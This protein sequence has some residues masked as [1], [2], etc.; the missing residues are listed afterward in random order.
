MPAEG[1]EIRAEVAHVHGHVRYG[2]ARIHHHDRT[3]RVCHLRDARD[4]VDRA[5]HVRLMCDGNDP[6]PLGDQVRIQI[7]ASVV[8]DTEP[9]QGGAGALGD[10]LPRHEICVVFHLRDQDLV[11]GS[12][13]EA[14][15]P[16]VERGVAERVRDHV[17]RLSR[18]TREDDLV[19]RRTDEARHRGARLLV[20]IR[21]FLGS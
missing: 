13:G 1:H 14:I 17:Q 11:A 5:E 3:D 2:L 9:S 21:S 19:G 4:G 20:G 7:E 8:G 18:V 16:A 12:Q 15:R 10:L 6:G